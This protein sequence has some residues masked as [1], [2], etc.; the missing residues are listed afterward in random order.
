MKK[1]RYLYQW[2]AAAALAAFSFTFLIYANVD[3]EKPDKI[4]HGETGTDGISINIL[5][6]FGSLERNEVFFLHDTHT[7]ALENINKGCETCHLTREVAGK[8]VLSSKFRRLEDESKKQV[9]DVYHTNCI[10]C[11]KELHDMG[12]KTGPTELCGECHKETPADLSVMPSMEFDKYLHSFHIEINDEECSTCHHDDQKEASCRYCHGDDSKNPA[13]MKTVSHISCIG[14]HREIS[15]P[16][17]CSACHDTETQQ[18]FDRSGDIPRLMSDQPDTVLIGFSP[19]DKDSGEYSA[20]INPVPF[21]HRAHEQYQDTCR[22]CHHSSIESCSTCHTGEGSEK[23]KLIRA[24]QAMH[25][26]GSERSC[27]GCHEVNKGKRECAGCHDLMGTGSSL[28]E[29]NCNKCH[30]EPSKGSGGVALT[31]ASMAS[32]LLESGETADALDEKDIPETVTIKELSSQYGAVELPHRQIISVLLD[33]IKNS[34]LADY[35]HGEKKTIC[36]ACHHN[37]PVSMTPP[38]CSSCHGKPFDELDPLRPG[39]KAAYHQQCMG[40]HD[41]MDIEQPKSTDCAGCHEIIGT[42]K[43]YD[44]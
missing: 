1:R 4:I 5:K 24:E 13:S 11:H 22:A 38:R 27:L 42:N 12:N 26:P 39:L 34:K 32:M 9:M 40:C 30:M 37:S 14:C 31:P 17:K 36:Q 15:G 10:A 29:N 8:Q 6:S 25:Q 43:L 18:N 7:E 35:F 19:Q 21:D 33:D 23:G 44:F 20:G 41:S 16:T 2:I 3:N 28:K